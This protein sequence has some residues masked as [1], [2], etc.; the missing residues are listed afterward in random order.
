[1]TIIVSIIFCT[2]MLTK[3]TLY[4]KIYSSIEDYITVINDIY[5]LQKPSYEFCY[6]LIKEELKYQNFN[7]LGTTELLSLTE[8]NNQRKI[9]K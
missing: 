1:M 8:E 4:D 5:K 7:L 6:D 3:R 2:N 9:L